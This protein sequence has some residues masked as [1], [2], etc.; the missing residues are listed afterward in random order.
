MYYV[1]YVC[2]YLMNGVMTKA[3]S[4]LSCGPIPTE[5]GCCQALVQVSAASHLKGVGTKLLHIH[6]LRP[7]VGPTINT[8]CT[9]VTKRQYCQN[10][11]PQNTQ[12][13]GE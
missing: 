3:P 10:S 5:G 12:T 6:K 7:C 9:F 1:T 13:T 11:L 8:Q 4:R 2:T